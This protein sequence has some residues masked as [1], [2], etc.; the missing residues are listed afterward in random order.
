VLHASCSQLA[1]Q[2]ARPLPQLPIRQFLIR[3]GISDGTPLR[4]PTNP[5]PDEQM[6]GMHDYRLSLGPRQTDGP[7]EEARGDG[8]IHADRLGPPAF[9]P[10]PGSAAVVYTQRV[11]R[12]PVPARMAVGAPIR[13]ELVC[14]ARPPAQCVRRRWAQRR[15]DQPSAVG[16]VELYVQPARNPMRMPPGA[17]RR[18]HQPGAEAPPSRSAVRL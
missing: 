17:P 16:E 2:V 6:N 5:F 1:G 12:W 15:G 18:R 7:N 11:W 9:A 14:P 3:G 13:G 8:L 4:P 10:G